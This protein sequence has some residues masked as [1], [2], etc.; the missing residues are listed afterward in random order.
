VVE[1]LRRGEINA[2]IDYDLPKLGGMALDQVLAAGNGEPVQ[3]LVTLPSMVF[4]QG[5]IDDPEF[6]SALQAT[7]CPV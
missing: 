6:A 5:T 7:P 4:T 2:L 1:A 3:E